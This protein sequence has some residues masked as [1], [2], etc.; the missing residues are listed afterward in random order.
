MAFHGHFEHFAL[1]PTAGSASPLHVERLCTRPMF[2]GRNKPG[3]WLPHGRCTLRLPHLLVLG[4]V[5]E[6]AVAQPR[7]DL[8][9]SNPKHQQN[10]RP[11]DEDTTIPA[12]AGRTSS[13]TGAIER[14]E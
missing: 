8:A 3:C 1:A 6:I 9:H 10:K 7:I 12:S 11:C 14:Q 13:R 5:A 4:H 2:K